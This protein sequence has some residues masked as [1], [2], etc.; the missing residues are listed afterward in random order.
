MESEKKD[1]GLW[2]IVGGCGC[3]V[4]AC[5]CISC[6]AWGFLFWGQKS[7]SV[8][9][10]E[11]RDRMQELFEDDSDDADPLAEPDS[12]EPQGNSPAPTLPPPP[13]PFGQGLGAT[14]RIRFHVKEV[15]GNS[16]LSVGQECEFPVARRPKNDGGYWCQA[17]VVCGGQRL[18]GG[19]RAGFFPC[20]FSESSV[21]GGEAQTTA[22]DGDAAFQIDEKNKKLLIFD[23]E[24]GPFGNYRITAEVVFSKK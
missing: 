12:Q 18:Y 16:P 10:E 19:A 24:K 3:L 20:V 11:I 14:H 21:R 9:E 23:D 15:T 2:W 7:E 22:Q 13:D 4:I 5:C 17:E 8:T 6:I 1:Q